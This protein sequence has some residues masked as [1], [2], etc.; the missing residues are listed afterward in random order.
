M[1]KPFITLA[2]YERISTNQLQE[3]GIAHAKRMLCKSCLVITLLKWDEPIPECC[4]M[5]GSKNR[6]VIWAKVTHQPRSS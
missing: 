2:C 4:D 1:K 5:C 3:L 6:E